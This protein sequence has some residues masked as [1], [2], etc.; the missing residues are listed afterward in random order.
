[1]IKLTP[2]GSTGELY[3]R[4]IMSCSTSAYN[5]ATSVQPKSSC[6]T[7]CLYLQTYTSV[8]REVHCY[9]LLYSITDRKSFQYVTELLADISQRHTNNKPPVI[10]VGNKNDLVRK[11][12]VNDRGKYKQSMIFNT[13]KIL[14]IDLSFPKSKSLY[15]CEAALE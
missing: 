11:R 4:R 9:I 13:S 10:V 7:L 3:M 5:N 6:C 2:G 1:V 8:Y 15:V 12:Q 14:F